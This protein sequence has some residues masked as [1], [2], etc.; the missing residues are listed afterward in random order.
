MAEGSAIT[1]E[2]PAEDLHELRKS[3][4]KLRYLIEFFRSIYPNKDVA[5]LIKG[6]KTLLDNL[7]EFQDLQVQAF[8]L[9]EFAHQIF[10]EGN[11]PADTLLAM[12]MLVDELLN[13]QQEARAQFAD[14]FAAFAGSGQREIFM[15]LFA[16]NKVEKSA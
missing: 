5:E 7:G 2:S 13:H 14:R 16:P 9:R 8:K 10:S 6:I 1:Q 4:K 15:R 12:G 11:V 3:C